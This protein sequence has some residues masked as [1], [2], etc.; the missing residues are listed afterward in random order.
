M[1]FCHNCGTQLRDEALFCHVCGAKQITE[2]ANAAPAA[3]AAP[4]APEA[5][6]DAQVQIPIPSSYTWKNVEIHGE[7]KNGVGSITITFK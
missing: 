7:F 3:P 2:E 5:P 1:Y 4:K 6:Q